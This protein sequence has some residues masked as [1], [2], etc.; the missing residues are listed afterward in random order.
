[1]SRKPS[2]QKIITKS[3]PAQKDEINSTQQTCRAENR[4]EWK[5]KQIEISFQS[6]KEK[7]SYNGGRG[8]K[9]LQKQR[10]TF[11]PRKSQLEI[12]Y[13]H[14]GKEHRTIG[15]F[16]DYGENIFFPCVFCFPDD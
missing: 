15:S 1:M 3:V 5:V 12:N 9:H 14:K 2:F 8:T 13:D 4:K 16:L 11:K 10:Q 7:D 6:V